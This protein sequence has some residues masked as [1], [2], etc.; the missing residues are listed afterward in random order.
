MSTAIAMAPSPAPHDRPSYIDMTPS[1][2]QRHS[3]RSKSPPVHR[4]ASATSNHA[5]HRAGSGSPETTPAA[6]SPPNTARIGTAPKITIKKEMPSSPDL[7]TSRHRPRKLDLSK[8]TASAHPATSRPSAGPLT[9]RGGDG[10]LIHDVGLACLSPGFVTQDPTMREQLQ[11]SISVREQQRQL[12]VSRLQQTAKPG[13]APM[14]SA[15]EREL[16]GSAFPAKTPGTSKRKAP[17]GLSI[18]APSHEQFAHERV[19]QSAPL[20]QSFTGRHQA[21]PLTRHIQNPSS[22][23]ANTSHIHHVPATQTSNRLPPITDVFAAEGLGA[24]REVQTSRGAFF[25]NNAG[26]AANSSHSNTRPA[27]PSP[28]RNNHQPPPSARPREYRSAEDAQAELAGGRPEL[29]PKLV[30]YGRHQQPPTPPSPLTGTAM[31][32]SESARSGGPRRRARAEYEEGGSPPLGTGP[33]ASR[34]GPFGEGRDSPASQQRK[35]EEFIRLCDRAW[36]LFHS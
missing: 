27:F 1:A 31:R 18:V 10:L 14:E 30:H 16:G 23:L 20:H 22:N 9:A 6:K 15:R 35:K 4:V 33:S 28:G 32:Y 3:D 17:P 26:S 13:D 36:D 24:H 7:S 19:I 2:P 29:L 25:P 12:I 8:N 34:R 11:R 21:H 5:D